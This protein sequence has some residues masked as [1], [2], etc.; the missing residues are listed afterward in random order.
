MNQRRFPAVA[1][2]ALALALLSSVAPQVRAADTYQ[3]DPVHSMVLFKVD[4]L[5][6]SYSYGRFNDISGSIVIDEENPANSSVQIEIKAESVD[7]HSA[8]RDQHLRSVD[9][10]N[11]KQFPV[12]SFKSKQ[13]KKSGSTYEIAGDLTVRGVTKPVTVTLQ[14]YRTGT[15]PWG[16]VR[17]GFNGSF[18]IQRSEYGVNYM[19]EGIG[20]DV[21]MLLT[22]EGIKQ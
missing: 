6:F 18:T 22:F 16:N 3:V 15:D 19:P 8:R 9:F 20:E 2:I 12:I 21:E 10:L 13:V 14:R 5:G 17:T 1:A 4:H 11:A 7:T